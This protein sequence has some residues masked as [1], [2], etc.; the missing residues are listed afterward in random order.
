M[1]E[2]ENKLEEVNKFKVQNERRKCYRA[3]DNLKKGFQPRSNGCRN[4]DGEI[5]REEGIVLQQWEQYFKELLTIEKEYEEKE[6][7]RNENDQEE[8]RTGRKVIKKIISSSY[9]SHFRD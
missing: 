9:S 7:K 4:K 2:W 1:K 5:I 3:I 8:T 6:S